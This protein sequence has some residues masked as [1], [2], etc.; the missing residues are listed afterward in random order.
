MYKGI[1]KNSRTLDLTA[2]SQIVDAVAPVILL[3]SPED[4]GVTIVGYAV[5]RMAINGLQAYLRHKT[6]GAL[7][8]K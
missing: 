3:L 1:I 4:L 2:L 7:G 8:D 5:I 6:T